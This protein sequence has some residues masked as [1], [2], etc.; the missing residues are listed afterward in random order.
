MTEPVQRKIIHIDCDCFFAA[1]EMRDNP[2]LSNVPIAVGGD[3]ERRGV[4]STCNYPARAFGVRSAMATAT[5]LR[6]CPQLQLLPGRMSLYKEVSDHVM[7]ILRQTAIRMEQ[8][9]ID[10]AYL[11]IHPLQSATEVAQQLQQRI[12][13][14][15][16]V[17]VSAG[18]ATNKLLAK[19]ASDW[20]KPNGLFVIHPQEVADFMRDLNVRKIPGI[21]PALAQRLAEQGINTCGDVQQWELTEL[22]RKFG[23]SGASLY[24]R[25]RGID[26]RPLSQGHERKSI[27]VECTFAKDLLTAEACMEQLPMLWERWCPR[28]K[29]SGFEP[30]QLAPFVKVKFADF[31]RTTLAHHDESASLD[32]FARL[33]QEAIKRQ[34]KG[35][36]LLGIGGRCPQRN[37]QQLSLFE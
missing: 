34:N 10:E 29:K 5:A 37:G 2:A 8:V 4:I 11:D 3:A 17:T 20:N 22:V 26:H 18:V 15:V 6:L 24:E 31:T 23:R 33:M 36:R 7:A 28:V 35:I 30:L 19:I 9:S 1:V 25:A 16:G 27:S 14:E 12:W 32:G 13:Q 21:G